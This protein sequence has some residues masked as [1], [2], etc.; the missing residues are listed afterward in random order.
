MKALLDLLFPPRCAGCRAVLEAPRTFCQ[1]CG[2]T[3]VELPPEHCPRCAEPDCRGECGHCRRR[4][5]AFESAT[6]PFLYGGA[7]ADAIHRFK[8]E[9]SPQLAGTLASLARPAL[10]RQIAWSEVLVPVPLHPARLRRRGYDQALLLARALASGS[11]KPVH[12]RA[13]RRTRETAPQVGRD[14]DQRER[15]VAGAFVAVAGLV[16]GRN[17]LLIDDVLTTGATA[18]EAARALRAAGAR[19][20]RLAAIARASA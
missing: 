8:Y 2:D 17:V 6:V 11:G 1:V 7:L 13:V 16:A 3:L 15:N 5:P 18:D 10:G 20:V 4:P 9:D 19:A 14:R 12:A